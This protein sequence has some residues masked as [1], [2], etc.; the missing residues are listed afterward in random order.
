[1]R[2]QVSTCHF[3]P[4]SG[5][6][7]ETQ[8]KV[9]VSCEDLTPLILFDRLQLSDERPDLQLR[10]ELNR[11]LLLVIG[12][13][14]HQVLAFADQPFVLAPRLHP[15]RAEGARGRR[16][17]L[18][19][20]HDDGKRIGLAGDDRELYRGALLE[21]E[22]PDVVDRRKRVEGRVLDRDRF[23]VTEGELL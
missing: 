4:R 21:I 6:T 10:T 19:S 23:A 11:D 20:L 13:P 3:A 9:T 8:S 7:I 22:E 5:K 1:M 14:E 15:D 17:R 2:G 18:A 12:Q 16:D